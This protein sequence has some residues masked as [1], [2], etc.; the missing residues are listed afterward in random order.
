M[1]PLGLASACSSAGFDVTFRNDVRVPTDRLARSAPCGVPKSRSNASACAG[2]PCSSME[3]IE[4]PSSLATT[5]VRS[6]RGSSGPMTSPVW[7]CRKVRSPIS[8][9]LR[10]ECSRPRLA[11]IAVLMVPSIPDRPRLAITR[12]RSPTGAGRA[13]RSR[14]RIGLDAPT[15]SRPPAG[16]ARE[17][18]PATSYGVSDGSSASSWS[19]RRPIARS[20]SC[21]RANQSVSSRSGA[22]GRASSIVARAGRTGHTPGPGTTST[23]TSS[24]SNK[25]VT[26]RDRVGRP[27]TTTRSIS[28]PSSVPSSSR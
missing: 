7:S 15:T 18:A 28:S 9:R 6:G 21:H 4:P 27:N 25:V 19:T 23:S 8:A 5:I 10:V 2:A 13:I 3:K 11:P 26:G 20:A 12:R 16:K 24:R 22:P 14:S 17:T 1:P